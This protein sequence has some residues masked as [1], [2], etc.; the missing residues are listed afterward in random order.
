MMLRTF[1]PLG[2]I[3]LGGLVWSFEAF[4]WA[5][6]RSVEAFHWAN[7]LAVGKTL[8]VRDLN[9]AIT[10]TP[11]R[12][13]EAEVTAQVRSKTADPKGIHFEVQSDEAGVHICAL[14]PGM[15]T[16]HGPV[17]HNAEE[18]D[19]LEVAFE[20][21]LPPGVALD[22]ATVNGPVDVRGASAAVAVASVNGDLRVETGAAPL[23]A[24]TVNGRVEV[25]LGNLRGDGD[26]R[27]GTVNGDIV[28]HLPPGEGV[29]VSARTVSGTISILGKEYP[30][31]VRTT[32]G[33]G[34]RRVSAQNVN[35][36]I[37]IR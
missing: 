23:H 21:H 37:A 6:G 14:W 36:S 30:E 1:A 15:K 5:E 28:A 3:S 13:G 33:R 25:R 17:E 26:V 8:S 2:V 22:A 9:G 35:G 10:V 16:C 11:A 29:E 7:S 19:D 20:V 32:V 31:R 24:D 34:G 27:L 4:A 18:S 12:G